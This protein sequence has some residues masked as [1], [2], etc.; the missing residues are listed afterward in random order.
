VAG[1]RVHVA[2]SRDGSV[3]RRLHKAGLKREELL[4]CSGSKTGN[5]RVHSRRRIVQS[6]PRAALYDRRGEGR[7]PPKNLQ[8]G[9]AGSPPERTTS[10]R[11]R[12][13]SYHCDG[14]QEPVTGALPL[15][16]SVDAELLAGDRSSG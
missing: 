16:M 11:D 1:D 6:L 7:R 4:F 14:F 10:Q 12:R 15:D 3:S 5:D 8:T 2:V 9:I 13:V